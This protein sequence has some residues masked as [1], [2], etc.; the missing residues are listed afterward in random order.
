MDWPGYNP[1]GRKVSTSQGYVLVYCPEHPNANKGG[2]KYIFEHRLVMSNYLQRP[3]TTDEVVHH[4]NGNRA[5]NRLENLELNT[6]SGHAKKHMSERT[7]EEKRRGAKP[8]VQSAERRRKPR[9]NITCACGCG[10]TIEDH[11]ARGRRRKYAHGH[12]TRGGWKSCQE[13]IGQK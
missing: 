5:D 13:S 4:I 11:D 7:I 6:N 2:G 10:T 8:I 3:L 12:N 1:R 9:T